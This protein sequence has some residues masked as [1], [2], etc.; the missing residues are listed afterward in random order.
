MKIIGAENKMIAFCFDNFSSI[1]KKTLGHNKTKCQKM[2][3]NINFLNIK[4]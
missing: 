3:K 2:F 4:T 1:I